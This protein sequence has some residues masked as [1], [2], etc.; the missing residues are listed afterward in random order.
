[1][2]VHT[3]Y[4]SVEYEGQLKQLPGVV[5]RTRIS[6]HVIFAS[7]SLNHWYDAAVTSEAV[8]RLA[9]R[10]HR[11]KSKGSYIGTGGLYGSATR[12]SEFVARQE[13]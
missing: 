5:G 13:A 6:D 2:L 8:I 7:S 10:M 9:Q 3:R 12:H 4:I 1:V 11:Q